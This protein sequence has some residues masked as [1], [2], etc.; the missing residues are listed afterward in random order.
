MAWGSLWPGSCNERTKKEEVTIGWKI[1]PNGELRGLLR[2]L[3][4]KRMWRAV[5]V[6]HVRDEEFVTDPKGS[7]R[8]SHAER[9]TKEREYWMFTVRCNDS[10]NSGAVCALWRSVLWGVMTVEIV[11]R[12]VPYGE[13]VIDAASWIRRE[14]LCL[15]VYRTLE[16]L[17]GTDLHSFC[18]VL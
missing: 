9:G 5:C 14:V 16:E 2:L 3:N 7:R 11:E 12:S 15:H 8:L 17:W 13:E 1:L 6:T 18:A 4:P 10:A